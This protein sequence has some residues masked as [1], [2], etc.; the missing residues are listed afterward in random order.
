MTTQNKRI[1]ELPELIIPHASDYFVVA[2]M[3]TNITKKIKVSNV[4]P[5]GTAYTT[6]FV[7]G[8]WILAGDYYLPV[9]HPLGSLNP[10][11]VIR[12]SNDSILVNQV[13]VES[14]A[15]IKIWVP[16]NPD[17]RFDGII[18]LVKT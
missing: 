12:D 4:I 18:S 8:D 13:E 10:V 6:Q 2:D 14:D 5:S 9:P 1:S 3:A 7:L 16:S 11:V 17:L 15:L